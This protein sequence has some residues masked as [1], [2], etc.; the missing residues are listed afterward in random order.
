MSSRFNPALGSLASALFVTA[1]TSLPSN[2]SAGFV[3]W[4]HEVI[5]LASGRVA[6]NI[7]VVVSNP[8]DRLLM[9]YDT[10]ISTNAPGGFYQS[11][12]NPFWAPGVQNP[13]NAD[14]S[15]LTIGINP[16]TGLTSSTATGSDPNFVNFNDDGG[17]TEFSTIISVPGSGGAGW[18]GT[19]PLGIFNLPVNGR[20]L[21]AHFVAGDGVTAPTGVV[22]WKATYFLKLANGQNQYSPTPTQTFHWDGSDTPAPGALVALAALPAFSRRR[23]A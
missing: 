16:N 23:R 17:A 9:V 14:D 1:V 19:N 8:A 20:I 22:S 12:A 15:F 13:A 2:A 6:M 4:D 11:Q 10:D 3:R 7:Y 5:Q 18:W 21:A